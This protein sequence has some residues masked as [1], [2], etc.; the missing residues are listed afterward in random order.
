MEYTG[1]AGYEY[2][3]LSILASSCEVNRRAEGH[4]YTT[5]DSTIVCMHLRS[6]SISEARDIIP[7]ES[8]VSCARQSEFYGM[9]VQGRKNYKI[10]KRIPSQ[11]ETR[12]PRSIHLL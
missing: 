6:V 10:I 8:C 2:V 1:E 11:L 12:D 5:I 9:Q 7:S 4:N 3:K